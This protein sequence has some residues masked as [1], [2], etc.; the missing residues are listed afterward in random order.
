MGIFDFFKGVLKEI[1][2]NQIERNLKDG[3]GEVDETDSLDGQFVHKIRNCNWIEDGE[4]K[5]WEKDLYITLPNHTS[6][7][8][9]FSLQNVELTNYFLDKKPFDGIV[10]YLYRSVTFLPPKE[11]RLIEFQCEIKNGI[12]DGFM[13]VFYEKHP[14]TIHSKIMIKN[15]IKNGKEIGYFKNGEIKYKLNWKDDKREGKQTDYFE[16][17]KIDLEIF[18]KNNEKDGFEKE[19][20]ANGELKKTLKFKNGKREGEY[21]EFYENGKVKIEGNFIN[22]KESGIWRFYDQKGNILNEK[23]IDLKDIDEFKEDSNSVNTDDL[24]DI[25]KI[26]HYKG[27]PYTG[28]AFSLI[29]NNVISREITF[30]NGLKHGIYKS[31]ENGK[32]RQEENY[33]DDIGEGLWKVY[34]ESGQLESG[35]LESEGNLK[36]ELIQTAYYLAFELESEKLGE[37]KVMGK[38]KLLKK[39]GK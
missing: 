35:Q 23:I 20:Y 33:K 2:D 21:E 15:D 17:G 9:D 26:T 14:F 13:T 18:H 28:V 1:K 32:L 36:D 4:L 22:N 39:Y 31:Y 30:K 24:Y 16:N 34:Y 8:V 37:K 6:L 10:Y 19:F 38:D 12:R 7:L 11:E 27:E 29:D 25:G 3:D 5:V